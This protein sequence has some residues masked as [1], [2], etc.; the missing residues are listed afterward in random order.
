MKL[1]HAF[2]RTRP[3]P[4]VSPHG[5]TLRAAL[6]LCA[7]STGAMSTSAFAQEIVAPIAPIMPTAPTAP[8]PTLNT[9][10]IPDKAADKAADKATDK[11]IIGTWGHSRHDKENDDTET[12]L[13]VF[14]PDGSYATAVRS[15]M[16]P[17][18]EKQPLASG[19]YAV[20]A[21]DKAG[22]TLALDRAPGDPDADKASTRSTLTLTIIDAN[23]LRAPD[24]ALL[25]RIK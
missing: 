13:I 1:L 18:R 23:T 14:K 7:I 6:L 22:F 2:S 3:E 16:F 21:A 12:T 24:G 4:L 25:N 9:I 11:A 8:R 19:R 10:A 5:T 17:D 20:T 15:S